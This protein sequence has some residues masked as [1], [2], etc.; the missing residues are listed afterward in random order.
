MRLMREIAFEERKK[1]I[2]GALI[3]V[4]A[5]ANALCIVWF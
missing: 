1:S 4:L 5:K 3:P 2:K